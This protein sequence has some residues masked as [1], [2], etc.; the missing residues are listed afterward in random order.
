LLVAYLVTGCD[1]VRAAG[2]ASAGVFAVLKRTIAEKSYELRIALVD[3]LP[4]DV[5]SS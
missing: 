2:R 1:L 5:E 4:R 3:F